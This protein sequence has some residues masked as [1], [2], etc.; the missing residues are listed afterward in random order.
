MN[1]DTNLYTKT[2]E[3]LNNDD[4]PEDNIIQ[5]TFNTHS[6]TNNTNP[7]S[8][9]K[10]NQY[11]YANK[12][13]IQI[14]NERILN[15]NKLINEGKEKI[16]NTLSPLRPGIKKEEISH[17]EYQ[18]N[19]TMQQLNKI[20]TEYNMNCLQIN[21]EFIQLKNKKNKLILVYNSLYNFKQKLL[22]KEKELK[23]K[24]FKVHKKEAEIKMKE[25]LIK[26]KF[27][28]FNNYINYETENL[29]NKY[30][31][32]KEYHQQREDELYKREEKIK[33]YEIIV[34][35]ILESKIDQNKEKIQEC[36]NLG[37]SIERKL[38]KE[39][40]EQIVKD[41]E[42]IEKEKENIEKE[43][44]LLEYEKEKLKKEKLENI[45]FKKIN[46]NKAKKLKKKE[47]MINN[48]SKNIIDKYPDYDNNNN[49]FDDL[50]NSNS[51]FENAYNYKSF[52][53]DNK[54]NNRK[55]FLTPIGLSYNSSRYK[56]PNPYNFKNSKN[57]K[58]EESF[59]NDSI[60]KNNYSSIRL[61]EDSI[62]QN[63]KIN[64]SYVHDN[65]FLLKNKS[66]SNSKN[67][68]KLIPIPSNTNSFR[69]NKIHQKIDNDNS[70]IISNR[71]M[72]LDLKNK[73]NLNTTNESSVLEKEEENKSKYIEFKSE[74]NKSYTEIN[75]K[76]FET[77]KALQ[78]IENQ[79]RKIKI[80]KDKLDKKM[81][82]SS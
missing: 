45:K 49:T 77:E 50:V 11:S 51:F 64:N 3:F 39:K 75:S 74:F 7:N 15:L 61:N 65:I 47:N 52:N 53:I 62:S 58:K 17:N 31:N 22:N 4:I 30:K 18:I 20:K 43:K 19:T 8:D 81:K 46:K 59:F 29:M 21:N 56:V 73:F 34:K 28:S 12:S 25:S 71:T 1:N 48:N 2:K 13:N 54:Y 23:K 41:I 35:K 37:N 76:I 60:Y 63:Y 24:E 69:N 40:E 6:I 82:N 5:N 14:N 79:E 36:I 16:E 78:K 80:I 33:E 27:G 44:E 55:K 67:F 9:G 57:K 10:N 32:L 38:E 68:S 26:N 72:N 70:N 42:I 66:N